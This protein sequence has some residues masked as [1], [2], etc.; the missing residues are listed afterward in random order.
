M[1]L[2]NVY[3][4]FHVSKFVLE[5]SDFKSW[6]GSIVLCDWVSLCRSTRCKYNDKLM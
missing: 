6:W 5:S 4:F 3:N 2:C 1:R